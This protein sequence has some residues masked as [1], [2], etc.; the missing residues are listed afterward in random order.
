MKQK[1]QGETTT[2]LSPGYRWTSNTPSSTASMSS[3]AITGGN[4]QG[5][6]KQ[7]RKVDWVRQMEML[8]APRS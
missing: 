3:S 1:Q 5:A 6:E 4:K 2:P 7:M 8:N